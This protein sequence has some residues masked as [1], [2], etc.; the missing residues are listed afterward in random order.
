MLKNKDE[1]LKKVKK[2]TPIDS[3]QKPP[4]RSLKHPTEFEQFVSWMALPEPS[5]K[6]REQQEFAKTIGV[7]SDT[8]T[9]WKKREGFWEEVRGKRPEW[10]KEKLS[11]IWYALYKK[12]IADGSAAEV[13]LWLQYFDD[14]KETTVQ[15]N[16][17][18]GKTN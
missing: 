17:I 1:K 3:D 9:D 12:I 10:G 13:K 4:E 16:R 14:F 18:R 11:N 7:H 8:L 5:R 2:L 6:P 15:K